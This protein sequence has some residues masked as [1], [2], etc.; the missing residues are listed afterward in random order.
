MGRSEQIA[1]ERRRRNTDALG[2]KRRRLAVDESKLDRENFTYRFANDAGNRIHD[3]TVNDDWEVVQDRDGELNQSAADGAQ[4][5]VRAGVDEGGKS[6]RS[7]LLRKPKAYHD[8]DVAA[9]QRRIDDTETS[10]RAGAAPGASG[11]GTTYIPK[12]G[13]SLAHGS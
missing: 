5:A 10:L 4:V 13:I 12:D 9:T 6:M 8:A 1:Q 3:L 11:D 2:G 7:V